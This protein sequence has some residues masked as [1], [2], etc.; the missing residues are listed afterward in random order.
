MKTTPTDTYLDTALA[1]AEK[2]R[3]VLFRAFRN[4]LEVRSKGSPIN[5]V[6]EADIA[7]EKA[8]TDCI[9]T[10]HPDHNLLAEEH[11]YGQT[12]SPFTWIIDPLDGT[13]NFAHRLPHYAVSIALHHHGTTILGVVIDPERDECFQAVRGEGAFLNGERL[14]VTDRGELTQSLL[15]TGF[16]YDRGET[17]RDSIRKIETLLSLGI[18]DIRRTG[19]AALDLSWV[20]AGRTDGYFESMLSPWDFAA[21][22]LIVEEAGGHVTDWAGKKVAR[23]PSGVV[24]T[25]GKIHDSLLEILQT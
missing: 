10:R 2:A 14:S 6:T 4:P 24:A 22:A 19:A 5:L 17:M 3:A 1:A 12:D 9:K 18:M 11:D 16:Y 7:S 15:S 23:S 8:I 25:N 20:A 21:G 13:N